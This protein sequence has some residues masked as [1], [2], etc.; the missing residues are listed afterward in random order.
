M[1]KWIK[2]NDKVMAITGNDKGSTGVVL[3]RKGDKVIVQGLNL[4]KKTVKKSEQNPK[5][6]FSNIEAP[7]HVSNLVVCVN[8]KPVKLRFRIN[9]QGNKELYYLEEGKAVAYRQLNNNK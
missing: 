6:G 7:I 2:N 9:D 8:D 1:S 3:V 4:K 5:G